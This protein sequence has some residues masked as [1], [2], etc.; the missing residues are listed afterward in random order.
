MVLGLRGPRGQKKL[1]TEVTEILC[2]FCIEAREAQRGG[3]AFRYSKF[4]R[5]SS[6]NNNVRRTG[7]TEDTEKLAPRP[8]SSTSSQPLSLESK[9]RRN[10][11]ALEQEF[12]CKLHNPR[13][14]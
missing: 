7:V 13:V 9:R 5:K 2:G 12:E 10:R 11:A 4:E 14:G 1:N 6:L 3:A 8:R